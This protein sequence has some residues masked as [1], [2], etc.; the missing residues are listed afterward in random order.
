MISMTLVSILLKKFVTKCIKKS[1]GLRKLCLD[2]A[3]F[4]KF[5]ELKKYV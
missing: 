1:K 3:L 5:V 4:I 2:L